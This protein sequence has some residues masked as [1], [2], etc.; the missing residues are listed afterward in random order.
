MFNVLFVSLLPCGSG[1][2]Q[3]I[4]KVKALCRRFPFAHRRNIFFNCRT[5]SEAL[6]QQRH[7]ANAGVALIALAATD[8]IGAPAVAIIAAAIT[9]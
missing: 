1:Q 3:A 4:E 2:L 8:S 6:M 5:R 7:P 9:K